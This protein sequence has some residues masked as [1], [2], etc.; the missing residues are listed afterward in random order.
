VL[1][2]LLLLFT[3]LPLVEIVILA[4][5]GARTSWM[6]ALG[7]VLIPGLAGAWLLREHGWYTLVRIRADLAASRLP[8][9]SL[10]DG[11][12]IFI[13]AVLLVMPGVL[14]DVVAVLLLLPMTRRLLKD[15]LRLRFS[16]RVVTAT[17]G[18]RAR[19][20]RKHDEIIDVRVIE[21]NPH[22]R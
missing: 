12:L 2:R 21:S 19:E 17:A 8:A 7:L 14:T 10:F 5:I 13:A 1:P 22:D 20:P 6:V 15:Y 3:L 11:L 18:F 9:E 4:W 16:Q